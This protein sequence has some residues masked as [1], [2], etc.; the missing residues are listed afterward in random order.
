VDELEHPG[1]IGPAPGRD[2]VS[3]QGLGRRAAGLVERGNEAVGLADAA[4]HF[5]A[6]HFLSP[7]TGYARHPRTVFLQR[8]VS[9]AIGCRRI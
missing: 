2:A 3:R 9:L 7:G 6:V 8:A 4:R 5:L 1:V